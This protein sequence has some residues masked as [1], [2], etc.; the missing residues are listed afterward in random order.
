M[1]KIEEDFL[2]KFYLPDCLKRSED[3]PMDI[4]EN[5]ISFQKAGKIDN[6]VSLYK[7]QLRKR[8]EAAEILKVLE[9]GLKEE[10]EMDNQMRGLY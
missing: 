9:K 4:V 3:L 5:I 1:D 10:Q 7:E 8:Q 6:I 2:N